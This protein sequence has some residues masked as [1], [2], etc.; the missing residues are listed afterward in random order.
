MAVSKRFKRKRKKARR[1]RKFIGNKKCKKCGKL[2][3][4]TLHHY[5]CNECW[6]KRKI[7]KSAVKRRV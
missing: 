6:G 7:I 2:L 1:T 3:R 4:D 5:Y